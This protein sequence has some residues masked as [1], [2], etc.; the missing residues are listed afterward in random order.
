[1]A[2]GAGGSVE[3]ELAV[4]ADGQAEGRAKHLA[5]NGGNDALVYD[6][7][8]PSQSSELICRFTTARSESELRAYLLVYELLAL[9]LLY[10]TPTQ[11]WFTTRA[12]G[13]Y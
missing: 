13:R 7:L 3:A 4:E 8:D 9:P 10:L 11:P 1:M 12:C 2:G 6:L 5:E